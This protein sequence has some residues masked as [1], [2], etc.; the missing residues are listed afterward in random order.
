MKSRAT[1]VAAQHF[2]FRSW[3]FLG[4]MSMSARAGPAELPSARHWH[5]AV[6]LSGFAQRR[7]LLNRETVTADTTIMDVQA[8]QLQVLSKLLDVANLR[9][10]VIAQNIANV[11]TPGYHRLGVSF[12]EAFTKKLGTAP[13]QELSAIEPK[14][15]ETGGGAPRADGNDVDMDAEMGRLTKNALLHNMFTQILAGNVATMRSAITGR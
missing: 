13:A 2:S 11:N 15:L 14:V 5:E 7:S 3:K 8:S 6:R 4:Q 10:R 1:T 9:H 12:E